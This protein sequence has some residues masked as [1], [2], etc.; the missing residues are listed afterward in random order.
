[1]ERDLQMLAASDHTQPILVPSKSYAAFPVKENLSSSPQPRRMQES[2][3]ANQLPSAVPERQRTLSTDG[4]YG[5]GYGG[6]HAARS[7][8]ALFK[9]AR[10][11]TDFSRNNN[12]TDSIDLK[13]GSLQY[14]PPP[15]GP[16]SPRRRNYE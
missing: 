4:P 9:G 5:G 16:N 11:L 13:R 12:D 14:A 8:F 3:V 6:V 7:E 2:R 15:A 10:L 1:M